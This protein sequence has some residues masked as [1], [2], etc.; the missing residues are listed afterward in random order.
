MKSKHIALTSIYVALTSKFIG[1]LAQA[2]YFIGD[3]NP[4][5]NPKY[6]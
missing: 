3:T 5:R 4:N 1:A 2:T 6:T